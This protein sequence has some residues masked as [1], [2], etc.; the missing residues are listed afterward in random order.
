MES[1]IKNYFRE[2]G[3]V[4][5]Q[6]GA[7]EFSYRTPLENL[8]RTLSPKG[9][10]VVQEPSRVGGVGAPDFRVSGAGGAVVGYVECKKPGENLDDLIRGVQIKK[11]Q[12]L[13]PNILL[14]DYQHFILLRDGKE[15]ARTSPG[16]KT[17]VGELLRRFFAAE[18]QKIGDA[19]TLAHALAERCRWLKKPLEENLQNDQSSLRGLFDS[20]QKTIY[21]NMD[22]AAFADALAQTLVYGLLT[23]KLNITNGDKLELRT[24]KSQIPPSFNL[25]REIAGFLEE[26]SEPAHANIRYLIDDILAV[27]N[28]MDAA[29]VGESLSYR[30]GKNDGGDDPYLYFYETFLAAYNARLRRSR[31]V[32]YTPPSVVRFIVRIADSVL[33]RDLKVEGGLANERVTALDF[34]A[35]TGTFMLEMFRLVFG[36]SERARRNMLAQLYLL[37][38]FFGFELLLAPFV[39][40]HLKLSRFLQD[41]GIVMGDDS[42]VNVFLTNTLEMLAVQRDMPFMPALAKE[43]NSAQEI[44]E[45]KILVI[46]GNP[47]YSGHGQT[48][49]SELAPRAHKRIEGKN[50][51][52]LSN[53]WI[54][55]L[56]SDYY[57]VDGGDLMEKNPKMLQDDYVKFIRFAQHK[58][59]ENGEGVV[60]VITNHSFLENPTFRGMRQSLMDSFNR[61]YF[62]DLHGNSKKRERA[63]D[64]GKDENVFDIQQG[65][66]VSIFVK[67]PGLSR[68]VFRADMFG[69]RKSKYEQCE[70]QTLRSIQW[71]KIKPT[72]PFYLFTPWDDKGFKDYDRHWRVTDIFRAH[73]SGITT[74]R[75]EFAYASDRETIL[76]R[77]D[78]MANAKISDEAFQEKHNAR[79]TSGW[80]LSAAR[81]KIRECKNR[82]KHVHLCAYRPFD[83]R[84]CFHGSETME[85][86]RL[87]VMQHMLAG[88]N[89]G[90]VTV[91]QVAEKEF[92]HAVISDKIID[93]RMTLSNKGTAYLFPLYRFDE[94]IGGVVRR[95]NF[96][97]KFRRWI[98]NLYGEE[99]APEKILGC[100]Y[101]ILHSPDYR[102]RYGEF[103]RMDFP[104]I[105][106]PDSN[107]EFLR[108]ANIGGELMSAHLLRDNCDGDI[109]LH[110]KGA[111]HQ[112]DTVRHDKGGERL[113]FNKEEYY[114]P[115]SPEVFNFQIGG[116]RPLHKFL[117]LRKGRALTT[118]EMKTLEKAANA[119]AFTLKKQKEI[120]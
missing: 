39:I 21:R 75:D 32:Y 84:W 61:L 53:T 83:S 74:S 86:S 48:P 14:T 120:G 6:R 78:D 38:N 67:K 52:A 7:T 30:K 73:S 93:T 91:R 55:T 95:E 103:L 66:A 110:G 104:R 76:A 106:F 81:R 116:Y 115:I 96:D 22:A 46:I 100:I 54:G 12:N 117:K 72:S 37:K 108:L 65:V 36:D 114:A 62:L 105:P 51:L 35:G 119:V 79:E 90:L 44:K 77:L 2:V 85:R 34:A 80:T 47:P 82:E 19:K 4:K 88:E 43:S 71:E 9:F 3:A 63:P 10:S 40:A 94:E 70:E 113:Y 15:A 97:P 98:N 56:L 26:L 58:I 60:A 11:Y 45:S 99:H 89:L 23:A 50:V 29:A 17:K 31:G 25:L 92:N 42:R 87:N 101:A 41:S 5:K 49:G 112:V 102:R 33:R 57:K 69:D 68:G 27:V 1:E 18:P 13:S 24:V 20:F 64:G 16:E 8:L 118:K 109:Q 107:T 59:D 28:H 111:S